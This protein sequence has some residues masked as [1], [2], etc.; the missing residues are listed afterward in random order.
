MSEPDPKRDEFFMRVGHCITAW[1]VL[2]DRLFEILWRALSCPQ[3]LAA[4]VYYKTPNFEARL[5]LTDELI[6]SVLLRTKCGDHPHADLKLWSDIR[7]NIQ[8][9]LSVRRRIAHQPVRPGK[10]AIQPSEH[11]MLGYEE[12]EFSYHELYASENEALR[13]KPAIPD[14]LHINDLKEHEHTVKLLALRLRAFGSDALLKHAPK[15]SS[16][17]R[18][19]PD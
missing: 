10:V 9:Q 16:P 8:N 17:S 11:E 12:L 18:K 15:P 3:E 13:G 19:R 6:K 7:I 4:I 14:T 5:M 1:A 2:E